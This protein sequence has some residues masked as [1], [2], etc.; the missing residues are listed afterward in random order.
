MK[1]IKVNDSIHIGPGCPVFIIAEIGYNFNTMD[2]AFQTVDAAADCGVDAVKFQTFRA[3][4]IVCRDV[5][6]PSEAGGGNQ[7]DEFK[8]YE[9]S[10]EN[11]KLLFDYARSKGLIP[12]STP[13]HSSDLPLL[14]EL[15]MEIYKVGSDDLTNIPFQQAVAKLGKPVVIST[16]MSWLHEVAK[17]ATAIREIGNDQLM[18]LHCLSNY[19][20]K[21]LEEVNLNVLKTLSESLGLV[22]GYSD[23]TTTLSAPIAA[24]ALGACIYERHFTINKK[25]SVPDAALSADPAE[26]KM[27]VNMIRETEMMLGDGLKKPAK[28]EVDMRRDTRKSLVSAESLKKGDVLKEENTI[29][30]RPGHGIEPRHCSIAYGMRVNRDVDKDVNITWEML[31]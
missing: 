1:A 2:E 15:G 25:L 20:I 26:M 22:V 3:E 18:I 10:A 13:S 19:P 29:I 6:F 21:D 12:F 8:E 4:T 7:F 16:G 24:V 11:H 14:E 30:K 17:T 28:S 27:I 9:L 31:R 23:H 5:E